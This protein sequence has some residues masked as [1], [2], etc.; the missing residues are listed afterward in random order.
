VLLGT[1]PKQ[2]LGLGR[3]A[4][5]ENVRVFEK[6]ERVGHVAVAQGGNQLRL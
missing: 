4:H 3:F 1:V 6:Q 5:R 2:V